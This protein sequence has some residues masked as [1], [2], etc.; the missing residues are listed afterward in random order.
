VLHDW[1]RDEVTAVRIGPDKALAIVK[2]GDGWAIEKGGER[3]KA[4]KAAVEAWLDRLL[5]VSVTGVLTGDADFEST[6][7]TVEREGGDPVTFGVSVT[8]DGK[9][10][11]VLG[12]ATI[13]T[14]DDKDELLP[15]V[16]AMTEP[17][18]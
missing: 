12:G 9:R 8:G 2:D 7:L 18:K 10:V 15:D 1:R 5:K 4:A 16:A 11:V 6:P 13:A 14:V 17:P 3:T